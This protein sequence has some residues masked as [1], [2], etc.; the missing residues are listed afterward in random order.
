MNLRTAKIIFYGGGVGR[1]KY[2]HGR[3]EELYW[4]KKIRSSYAPLWLLLN[5][6]Q[7]PHGLSRN[8]SCTRGMGGTAGSL[9]IPAVGVGCGLADGRSIS[10]PGRIYSHVLQSI[11]NCSWGQP[12]SS[13]TVVR[14]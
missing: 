14:G 3:L 2:A 7:I 9:L 10:I 6:P 5:P 11:L 1:M 4:Q 8:P 12:A 13:S